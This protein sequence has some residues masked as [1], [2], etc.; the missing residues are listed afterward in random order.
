MQPEY[1]VQLLPWAQWLVD[2]NLRIIVMLVF[3]LAIP[4]LFLSW[5]YEAITEYFDFNPITEI[6][7]AYKQL[8]NAPKTNT[9]NA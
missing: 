6:I 3:T 9:T 2:H 7:E 5:I 8:Y 1:K 4:A